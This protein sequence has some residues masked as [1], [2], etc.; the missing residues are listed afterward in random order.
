ME[1]ICDSFSLPVDESRAIPIPYPIKSTKCYASA[2][3]QFED[4]MG[5]SDYSLKYFNVFVN[6]CN[7]N[8]LAFD[9]Y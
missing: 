1:C 5:K 8:P 9:G 3:K 7:E 6:I 4:I 2:I